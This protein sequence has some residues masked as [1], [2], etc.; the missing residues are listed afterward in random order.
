MTNKRVGEDMA[1]SKKEL[2]EIVAEN[3]SMKHSTV[4]EVITDAFNVISVNLKAGEVVD[5]TKFGKFSTV[6]R[7]GRTGRNPATGE[8][9]QIPAKSAVKFKPAKALKDAVA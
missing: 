3:V 6:Q 5:I 2:I 9:V 8:Q 1:L 4:E 7:E